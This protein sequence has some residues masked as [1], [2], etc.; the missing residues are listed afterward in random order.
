MDI[1]FA[2]R[3]E[4]DT[5]YGRVPAFRVH[6]QLSGMMGAFYSADYWYS[7][8]VK[9]MMV[10]GSHPRLGAFAITQNAADFESG[11]TAAG[12][13]EAGTDPVVGADGKAIPG[14]IARL[15][16]IRLGGVPQ[17]VLIR[18]AK[19]DN[20]VLL[21][22]HSGPGTAEMFMNVRCRELERFFTVVY[23]DQYGSGK[24]YRVGASMELSVSRL[25]ADTVEL[26]DYL[27]LRFRQS[28]IFLAGHSWGSLLGA[29][30][31]Q[32]HPQRFQA[33]IGI[34]QAV[35]MAENERLSWQFTVDEATRRNNQAAAEDLGRIGPPPYTGADWLAKLSK[36]REWLGKFGGGIMHQDTEYGEYRDNA[37]MR[38]MTAC[39]EYTPAE[40]GTYVDGLVASMERLW[41][42]VMRIN[43]FKDVPE[44]A[45]PVYFATGRYDQTCPSSIS[46]RYFEA[47]KAPR[48]QWRWFEESAHSPIF[49]ESK[50]FTAFMV[51]TV[52]AECG[53]PAV[54]A[55]A[56]APEFAS[57]IA[58]SA[59]LRQEAACA[60]VPVTARL[61]YLEDTR[62]Y[63]P[64]RFE[65]ELRGDAGGWFIQTTVGGER[66]LVRNDSNLDTQFWRLSD[67]AA[68]TDLSVTRVGN[69]LVAAGSFKGQ[70]TLGSFPVDD[71][72]WRQSI[73]F[74]AP[75]L[76]AAD[77]RAETEFWLLKSYDIQPLKM[78][79]AKEAAETL[80]LGGADVPT[81]RMKLTVDGVP[82]QFYHSI[83]WYRASDGLFVKY[84]GKRDIEREPTIT[85][86]VD[87]RREDQR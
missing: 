22:L 23:W 8:A 77:G 57:G 15:E 34:G 33:F 12:I 48:K 75:D 10:A 21:F 30:A 29:M 72:P 55:D 58:Q 1:R 17:W 35:D 64:Y 59:K 56:E 42:E 67:P 83:Y 26:S 28:K 18:G 78:R 66:H 38:E 50:A 36:Q 87:E 74:A 27:G 60:A 6:H 84:Q 70:P 62:N 52:L 71:A 41:P 39:K 65:Y 63:T 5:E 81:V 7:L 19:P 2:E 51:D 82:E 80:K 69:C 79:L 14:S 9:P 20:P 11:R 46:R 61:S 68:G 85:W 54:D 25:V 73:D 44:L 45:V 43:L 24:S 40:K 16:R 37:L 3:K 49:E 53:A 47:L 4:I 31:V 86:L 76:L 32:R 13:G